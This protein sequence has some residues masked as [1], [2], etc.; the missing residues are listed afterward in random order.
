[1]CYVYFYFTIFKLIVLLEYLIGL[2]QFY[3]LSPS[4]HFLETSTIKIY[5]HT[6]K[7]NTFL[8]FSSDTMCIY[9]SA[10]NAIL[11]IA[12]IKVLSYN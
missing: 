6:Y 5:K 4:Y 3:L 8:E 10:T 7:F 12:D 1:M 9:I 11:G 2:A